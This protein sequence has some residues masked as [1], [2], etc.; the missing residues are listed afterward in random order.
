MDEIELLNAF[1]IYFELI[2]ETLEKIYDH[3]GL[4]KF[5][6]FF[7]HE[8]KQINQTQVCCLDDSFSSETDMNIPMCQQN[9]ITLKERTISVLFQNLIDYLMEQLYT[10]L[11]PNGPTEQDI[12][13][14][15]ACEVLSLKKITDID[16]TAT[17]DCSDSIISAIECIHRFE[18]AYSPNEKALQLTTMLNIIKN[19]IQYIKGGA[20]AP[21]EYLPYVWYSI[22]KAK[23]LRFVTNLEYISRFKIA[24]YEYAIASVKTILAQFKNLK[25]EEKIETADTPV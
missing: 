3:K 13:F 7:K 10:K 24:K 22:I 1:E 9:T 16:P 14:Y 25:K 12:N 5:E 18:K 2:K 17:L 6:T 8:M 4:N 15:N 19:K 11:F 20:I 21:D 23:P